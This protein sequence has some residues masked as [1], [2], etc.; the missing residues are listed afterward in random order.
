MHLLVEVIA[1]SVCALRLQQTQR[2]HLQTKA[3]P[4][5]IAVLS[6]ATV[7]AAGKK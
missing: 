3:L 2:N 6:E 5:H 7:L 4:D 1:L